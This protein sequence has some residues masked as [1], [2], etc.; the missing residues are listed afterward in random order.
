[1]GNEIVKIISATVEVA[2]LLAGIFVDTEGEPDPKPLAPEGVFT[3]G[4]IEWLTSGYYPGYAYYYAYNPT[5]K[6]V[7]LTFTHAT[8]NSCTTDS[9]AVESRY[10]IDVTP[11]ILDFNV[12]GGSVTTAP[13]QPGDNGIPGPAGLVEDLASFVVKGLGLSVPA[14]IFPGVSVVV[15]GGPQ[16]NL[17]FTLDAGV[18]GGTF[19]AT[20]LND[21]ASTTLAGDLNEGL[22]IPLPAFLNLNGETVDHLQLDMSLQVGADFNR[23]VRTKPT[24]AI[25]GR[26]QGK[27]KRNRKQEG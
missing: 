14:S 23:T 4:D 6:T 16:P 24:K 12:N 15:N 8:D 20:L 27:R 21:T 17:E 13:M 9:V 18:L 22:I 3:T 5:D 19:T 2:E 1:M 7:N 26:P 25:K 10:S 11:F